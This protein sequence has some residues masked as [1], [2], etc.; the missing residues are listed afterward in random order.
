MVP[1]KKLADA[2]RALSMDAVQKANSGH[3]GMPMGMADIAQ[4]LF[5]DFLKHNPGDPSWINRDRF[6]LSNGHGS[7]LLYSILYLTGYEVSIDDIKNF[8]QLHSIT[9]GHPEYGITPGV[10][11]TTGPLGQG[12]ANAVGMAIAEKCLAKEFNRQEEIIDHNTYCFVGDGCLMEGVSHEVASLA[13]T[14]GL[15]KLIVFW[16][17]NGISIDGNIEGWF[18]ENTAKRFESYNWQVIDSVDGHNPDM[19]T[20]AINQAKENTEQPTLICCKTTIGYGSPNKS[21]TAGVHGSPLGE[22]ELLKTKE[23][24]GWEHEKFYIPEEILAVWDMRAKGSKLQEN[25]ESSF[26]VYQK[27]NPDLSKELLR[28]INKEMPNGFYKEAFNLSVQEEK[29]I[30]TRKASQEVLNEFGK[31][32]PEL[33]G[34]SADLTG[35]NLTLHN[36]SKKISKEDFSGNYLYY[37]VREFGMSAIMNGVALHG[38]YIPYGGTF[39]VFSDYCRNAIRLSALMRQRVVYVMTHD[40]IGLGEDGPTHQPI[41]HLA[42]LRLIPNLNVWRPCDAVETT[43]AWSESL[44]ATD[45]P[46]VL[47]LSRQNLPF[48]GKGQNGYSD[49]AKG[50]YVVGDFGSKVRVVVI[51]TGSE[52]HIAVDAA[53]KLEKSNIGVRIVSMPCAE[54]FARQSTSYQKSVLTELPKVAIEAGHSNYWHRWVGGNGQILGIDEFGDSAPGDVLYQHKGI[55]V[56][57]L[58]SKIESCFSNNLETCSA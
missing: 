9:P 52:V 7:M 15:G 35:S 20:K 50:G 32:L 31:I 38:G 30:A 21:G 26:K 53:K 29:N 46:S 16:D 43:V 40:S 24:I 25:W 4:V 22:E 34:G 57:N 42:S 12:M 10:E 3:P 11:T 47:A 2:I 37:G 23:N 48:I 45:V 1:R 33:F 18:S 27:E 49:I 14:L 13:G 5:S 51:A 28:R 19:I 55:T 6:V 36:A 8:R 39:L 56:D 44:I 54:I 41:E 17:Q 58:I